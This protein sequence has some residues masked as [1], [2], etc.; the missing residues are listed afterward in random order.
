MFG[1]PLELGVPI[2]CTGDGGRCQLS[3]TRAPRRVDGC[4]NINSG[5]ML[6]SWDSGSFFTYR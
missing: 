6:R 2:K 5:A 1:I 3:Y 4:Y